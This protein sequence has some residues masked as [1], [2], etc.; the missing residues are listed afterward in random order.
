MPIV[1]ID[2]GPVTP[3]DPSFITLGGPPPAPA[4]PTSRPTLGGAPTV[5]S[6]PVGG[7]GIAADATGALPVGVAAKGLQMLTADPSSPLI[8]QCWYRFDTHQ[9]CVQESGAVK[10]VTLT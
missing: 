4:P 3:V 5:S 9:F 6:T 7:Q 1:R 8:G 10:R 2:D